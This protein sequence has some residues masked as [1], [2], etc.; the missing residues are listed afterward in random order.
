MKNFEKIF[1]ILCLSIPVAA[2]AASAVKPNND[3]Q[4]SKYET[5]K[6]SIGA[7]DKFTGQVLVDS[8]FK[9]DLEDGY[10]GAMVNFEAGARAAWHSHPRGQTLIVI[11]GEGRVQAK[12]KPAQVIK[13]GD[14]VWIPPNQVHWH[15]AAADHSMSHIAIVEAEGGRATDWMQHVTDNEYAKA[16]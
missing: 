11:E 6:A 2:C 1:S 8:N 4:V 9:S 14:V 13:P 5:Q 16:Q 15:G 7:A 3:V 12:G 10:S